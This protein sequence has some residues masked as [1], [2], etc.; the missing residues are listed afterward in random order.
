MPFALVFGHR[1][2]VSLLSRSIENDSLPP[3]LLFAGPAGVGKRLTAIAVAQALNCPKGSRFKVQGSGFAVPGSGFAVP[4]SGF[5]VP[6]SMFDACGTCAAC[7]RISRGV[8]PDVPIV[9]QRVLAHAAATAEPGRRIDGAK[10]LLIKTGAGG[11]GDREQLASHLRAMASL[12]RDVEVL[13][14]RADDRALA[15]PD[16]RPAL[17]RLT[18]AY[19]GE[20]GV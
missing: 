18:G 17:E 15:N 12:L 14:T 19:Q 13:A 9:G 16:V 3:S 11:A 20:R 10:E 4:G 6:G 7:K 1:R 5:T 8:H 2:L